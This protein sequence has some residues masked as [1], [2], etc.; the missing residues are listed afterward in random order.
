MKVEVDVSLLVCLIVFSCDIALRRM[1]FKNRWLYLMV[2][3]GVTALV[4]LIRRQRQNTS[5]FEKSYTSSYGNNIVS[6]TIP[7]NIPSSSPSFGQC[8]MH[9][10]NCFNVYRCGYNEESKISVYVYPLTNY[11]D[12]DGN[13][14]SPS[15]S[16]EFYELMTALKGSSYYTDDMDKAC[17]IVPALDFLNQRRINPDFAG[18]ILSSL[19]R[20]TVVLL[21]TRFQQWR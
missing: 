19:P 10:N 14:L 16:R 3:L 5:G 2:F 21:M 13:Q 12:E 9:T 1:N 4:F 6:L 20:Y 18:R 7:N 8:R 11:L 17:I 15:N